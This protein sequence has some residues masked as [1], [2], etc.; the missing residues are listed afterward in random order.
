MNSRSYKINV[1]ILFVSLVA[2]ANISFFSLPVISDLFTS[3][4]GYH[5]KKLVLF[6][7]I[8]SFLYLAV[9]RKSFLPY[10]INRDRSNPYT[11]Y[12]KFY[13][14]LICIT[15][16]VSKQSYSQQSV[17]QIVGTYY[18]QF[19]I[20]FFFVLVFFMKK[21]KEFYNRVIHLLI[22]IGTVYA[23]YSLITAVIFQTTGMEIMSSTTTLFESRNGFVRLPQTADMTSLSSVLAYSK[24]ISPQ[25]TGKSRKYFWPFIICLI[26]TLFVG[27]SRVYSLACTFACVFSY[28]F[29]KKVSKAKIIMIVF[30]LILFVAFL[31]NLYQFLQTFSLKDS[32]SLYYYSSYMRVS[33]YEYYLSRFFDNGIIGF[34][35]PADNMYRNILTGGGVL[36]E[37]GW[38]VD[39]ALSDMGY[40]GYLGMYGILGVVSLFWLFR[41]IIADLLYYKKHKIISEHIE[42]FAIFIFITISYASMIFND[43][44]RSF[45]FPII[46]ALFSYNHI[47]SRTKNA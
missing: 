26:C 31:P 11:S 30:G 3:M 27:Q 29:C 45:Y 21:N 25:N 35:Y 12:V 17:R 16:L 24:W 22:V 46:L 23:V 2:M 13:L 39:L 38:K 1:N 7:V 19:C 4:A 18:Y 15:I 9:T 32:N 41:L 6:F 36:V 44:Q 8:L 5:N 34:G 14:I 10:V 42:T 37:G 28:L 43:V 40:I 20:L 47:I 33:G